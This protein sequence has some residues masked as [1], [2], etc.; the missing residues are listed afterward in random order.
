MN[1]LK[2]TTDVLN[3]N[4]KG[5]NDVL[6]VG[7]DDFKI[8]YADVH[9]LF[10]VDYNNG[11]GAPEIAMDLKVVGNGWWLERKEYDGAECWSYKEQP[12]EPDGFKS[13]DSVIPRLYGKLGENN[14]EEYDDEEY[15]EWYEENR[16]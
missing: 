2:E 5:W 9:K 3:E 8:P 4:D 14:D 15:N 1:L 6:W 13:I 12:K 10:D 7:G 11:Y 16:L